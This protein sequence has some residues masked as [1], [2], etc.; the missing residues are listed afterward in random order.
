MSS[1]RTPNII[2]RYYE[3]L[4]WLK[5]RLAKY[6]RNERYIF[7]REMEIHALSILEDLL[8]ADY[9]KLDKAKLLI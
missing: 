1:S 3:F 2:A 7:G 5:T 6:P 4:K 8:K 9:R